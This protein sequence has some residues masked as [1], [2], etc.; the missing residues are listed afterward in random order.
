MNDVLYYIFSYFML[1]NLAGFLLMG[2]DKIKAKKRGFRIP[3]ATLFVAAIFG[4]SI[5]TW[6][7]IY[8]FRHKTQH[9]YFVYGLPIILTLQIIGISALLYYFEP[10]MF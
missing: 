7:G 8:L 10:T 3:E 1:I 9:W 2:L 6:I 5:G 4:G